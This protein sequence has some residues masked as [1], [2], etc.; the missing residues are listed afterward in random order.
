MAQNETRE[1]PSELQL[2]AD[3]Y[4]HKHFWNV[5]PQP[6]MLDVMEGFALAQT[7]ALTEELSECRRRVGE[8]EKIVTP[9]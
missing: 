4:L 5:R 7:T 1:K 6:T 9:Y 3:A 8:L 2:A